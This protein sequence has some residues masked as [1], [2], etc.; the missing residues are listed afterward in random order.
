MIDVD[1]LISD[2]T[3]KLEKELRHSVIDFI[4]EDYKRVLDKTVEEIKKKEI[5]TRERCDESDSDSENHYGDVCNECSKHICDMC[6]C[7]IDSD[8]ECEELTHE[9]M[10]NVVEALKSGVEEEVIEKVEAKKEEFGNVLGGRKPKGGRYGKR[11]T[12]GLLPPP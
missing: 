12:V 8:S 6:G 5:D 11:F 9:Q 7:E 2:L 10:K 3:K 4:T 1:K